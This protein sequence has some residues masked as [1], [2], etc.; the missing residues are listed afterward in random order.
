VATDGTYAWH[1][2]RAHWMSTQR[3]VG[4]RPGEQIQSARVPLVVNGTQVEVAV[5][6]TWLPEPSRLPLAVGAAVGGALVL[7]ALFRHHRLGLV[8]LAAAAA[9]GGIGWWQ[10]RSLPAETGPLVVWWVLPAVAAVSALVA[11][12]L[13]RRLVSYA[14][15]LLAAME[16]AVWAWLRRDGAFRALIPTDAPYWLDRGVMAASAVV[17]VAAAIG[18]AV[19]LFRVPVSGGGGAGRSR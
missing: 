19:A 6:T 12:L 7:L 13:G 11:L 18:A 15:V 5:S 9:A 1:D 17:A 10:Y 3:P 14:L 4:Y 2:H 8:L 16:L